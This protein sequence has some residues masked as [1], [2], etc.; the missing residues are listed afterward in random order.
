MKN[1]LLVL[2]LLSSCLYSTA[3]VGKTF[4]FAAPEVTISHATGQLSSNIR[5]S[6]FDSA[7]TVRI[8]QPAN[9]GTGIDFTI[10]VPANSSS[11]VDIT[12]DS[13]VV[14]SKPFDQVLQTGIK[15][16]SDVDVTVYYEVATQN[17]PDIFALK[18]DNGLGTEFYL[19]LLDVYPNH[20]FGGAGQTRAFSQFNIVAA[21]NNTTV[22]I[23]PSKD[24]FNHAGNV[25]YMI[26]LNEGETYSGR[27]LTEAG[28]SKPVGTIISSDKPIAVTYADDSVQPTSCFDLLGDQLV[29][30]N[31]IGEEYI[32]NSNAGNLNAGVA[33]HVVIVATENF[34]SIER[35][36]LPDTVLFAGQHYSDTITSTTYYRA[37]KPIYVIQITGF[38]CELGSAILPPLN[39]A[40]SDQ[41]S[42]GR[43]G[44]TGLSFFLSLLV[45]TGAEG[46]FTLNGDA[47]LIQASDFAVV[48][49]TGG[50]WMAMFKQFN[51]T[52]IPPGQAQLVQNTT[53][54]FSL[55]I[56][57][58]NTNGGTRYGYFSLFQSE[59]I[60]DANVDQFVCSGNQVNLNGSVRGGAVTGVWS[61]T[62][63]NGTFDDDTDL[64]TT[65]NPTPTDYATGNLTFV[66]E[67]TGQCFAEY[68][69]MVVNFTP[70]PTVDAGA[71][72]TICEN[73]PDLTLDATYNAIVT[74]GVQWSTKPNA[75][76]YSPGNTSDPTV[77]TPTAGQLSGGSFYVYAES[78][79]VGSCQPVTDS[80]LVTVLASPIV[81]AGPAQSLCE[82]NAD[83]TLAGSVTTYVGPNQGGVWS[84]GGN[85]VTPSNNALGGT[86]T[87]T[88]TEIANGTVTLTLS[89]LADPFCA[90]ETDN[91]TLTITSAPTV[92]A[93]TDQILCANNAAVPLAG[94][95]TAPATQATWIGGAGGFSSGRNNVNSIYTPTTGEI[96]AGTVTLTL[97][98]SAGNGTCIPVSDDVVLTYTAAPTMEAG[99]DASVCAN[100]AGTNV[101][102]VFT[103][104][105][106]VIWTNEAGTFTSTTDPL[107]YNPT[108]AE[109]T[110]GSVKLF[111]T[112]D[113]VGNC[114]D[115]IDSLTV[116]I[117]AAPI[118]EAG[119]ALTSCENNPTDTLQGSVTTFLGAGQGTWSG[120]AGSVSPSSAALQGIY[121]PSPAEI[122]NGTVLLTLTSTN[123]GICSAESDNVTLTILPAPTVSAGGDQTVCSNNADVTLNGSFT[124][125][126]GAVWVGGLGTFN[127][128]RN[129][130]NAVYT[131]DPTEVSAGTVS[132]TLQTVGNGLCLPESS[133]MTITFSASPTVDAGLGT[134]VC[135]NNSDASLS[136][137][138][139]IAT[140]VSW[141][142]GAG[143]YLPNAFS[144]NI[145]YQPT[146]TEISNGTVKLFATTTGIGNC[147]AV[148]DSVEITIME[149]PVVD[150][151][152]TLLAC[153]NNPTVQLDGSVIKFGGG[154]LGEGIWS[155]STGIINPTNDALKGTFTPTP[156]EI[157]NGTVLLTLTSI[158]NGVCNAESDTVS[159]NI[160]PSPT[161]NAG[162]DQFICK[163]NALTTLAGTSANAS[164]TTWIGGSG[165]FSPNRNIKTATYDPTQA[166]KDNGFVNL[167]L[168]TNPTGNCA[169][170]TDQM[171]INFTSEPT[172]DAGS[173]TTVC[174]NNEDVALTGSVSGATGGQW[175]NFGGSFV[176]GDQ[177]TLSSTYRPSA[178]EITA[179]QVV[180]FLST[181]GNGT[182]SSESDSIIV[183]I[184]PAPIVDAGAPFT[185]C[186]NN[187]TATLDG[188]FSG[189]GGVQWSNG[190]GSFIP[191]NQVRN[192]Q[193]IPS[194]AEITAGFVNLILTTTSN[195]LCNAVSDN[196]LINIR[197]K[198]VVSAG[199]DVTACEN[200]PGVTLTGSVSLAGGLVWSGG[201]GTF[202]PPSADQLTVQYNPTPTEINSG[203]VELYATS[204]SNALCNAVQDTVLVT[205]TSSPIVEAGDP[206]TVCGNNANTFLAGQVFGA[207]GGRWTNFNG[208]FNPDNTTL[209]ASYLPSAQ[210]ISNGSVVLYLESTGNGNCTAVQD[211]VEITI[212]PAPVASAGSPVTVCANNPD[213]SLAGTFSNAGGILWSGGA[214]SFVSSITDK[215]ATYTPTSGEI[216]A[217]SVTLTMTTTGNNTCF[218][219]S[220]NIVITI[221]GAP[222]ISAGSDITV[223]ANNS[224]VNLSGNHTI[225][226]GARWSGGLGTFAPND[227]VSNPVYTPTAAEVSSGSLTLT[228]ATTGNGICIPETDDVLITFTAAPSVEAGPIQTVC[229]N[230]SDVTLDGSF[231][232]ATGAAWSGF[233]GTF[234]PSSTD[235]KAIYT[236]SS[237]EVQAGSI[238]LTLSTTGNGT[239]SAVSDDLILNFSPEPFVDAGTDQFNCVDDMDT[240][241]NGIVAGGASTGRW[242]SSGT[243]LF[244]PADNVLNATY[245]MSAQDSLA[246][247]VTLTLTS[248]GNTNGSC[249][250]V[251]NDMSIFLTSPGIANAGTNKSV[252]ANNASV[253]L[254]GQVTGG[255]LGGTWTSSGSGQFLPDA[256]S[257]T[258]TYVPSAADT[259]NGNITITLTANS[260]DLNQDQMDLTITVGPTVDAGPNKTVCAA[261]GIIQLEGSVSGASTTGLWTP[262]SGG[263]ITP[264]LTSLTGQYQ[265]TAADE[266]NGSVRLLLLSTNVGT[267]TPVIDTVDFTI[268]QTGT[269]T[270]G[271]DFQVCS[272]NSDVQ[273]NGAFSGGATFARW[274]TSGT[275]SFTP[276]DTAMNALYVP[277]AADKTNGSVNLKYASNSC[278]NAADSLTITI[279]DGPVVDAGADVTVCE[280]N[281]QVVLSGSVNNAG[282]G[283]WTSTGSG[284]FSPTIF[285]LGATYTPAAS[286]V[287]VTVYLTSIG[288]GNCIEEKDSLTIT[289]TPKPV[290]DAGADQ[291]ICDG[292]SRVK[293][294]GTVSQGA[295]TGTWTSFGTGGFD[296]GAVLL[297]TDY[298]L[299]ASDSANRGVMLVLASTGNGLCNAES[300]TLM[301]SITDVGTSDAGADLQ[302]CA[303]DP[304]V[305][306]SGVIQGGAT[307][308]YWESNGTGVFALDSSQLTNTY[309]PSSQDSLNGT[310]TLSLVSNSCDGA[311]DD[312]IITITAAPFVNAGPDQIKCVNDLNIQLGGIVAGASTTGQWRSSGSGTFIPNAQTLN[313]TYQASS[314]DSIIGSVELI[315]E[316]T[317]IGNCLL[318]SDTMT[319]R[320]TTGGTASAGVDQFAC[321]NV[322]TFPLSGSFGGGASQGT[323]SSTGTGIFLPNAFD[324]NAEYSPSD[325]DKVNGL[326]TLTLS[327]N[328]CDMASDQ[329]D[330][331]IT[332]AP[333]VSAGNNL[334]LCENNTEASLLGSVAGA[335]GAV[336]SSTGSG[337][338]TP[339]NKSLSANYL[340]SVVDV[341]AGSVML[342]LTSVGN[343]NCTAERD[344]IIITF[345]GGPVPDAGINRSVCKNSPKTTLGGAVTGVTTTGQWSTL[346]GGFFLPNDTTLNAEYVFGPADTANGFVELILTST[347][348]V[349]CNSEDDT[350]T[351]TLGETTFAD[352]GND[353]FLCNENLLAQLNGI[354]GGDAQGG[355]W[356]SNGTGSFSPNAS[357]LNASYRF[358]VADSVNKQVQLVLTATAGNGCSSGT[359]TLDIFVTAEPSVNAGSNIVICPGRDTVTFAATGSGVISKQWIVGGSG[360]I[361][362]GADTSFKGQYL[363]STADKLNGG[364][365]LILTGTNAVGCQ[366]PADTL[367]ITIGNPLTMDYL[368]SNLCEGDETSFADSSK[369]TFGSITSWLWRFG[370]ASISDVQHPKHKYDNAGI[371]EISLTIT[372]DQ[373][374]VDSLK[375]TM[376][377]VVGPTADFQIDVPDVDAVF[378]GDSVTFIDQSINAAGW[379]WIVQNDTLFTKDA[380][381]TFNVEGTY[382]VELAVVS[383]VGCVDTISKELTVLSDAIL[384]PNVPNAFSPNE[385]GLNDVYIVRGGPFLTIDFKI[386]NEWGNVV[387]EST[388]PTLGWDGTRDGKDQPEGIYTYTLKATTLDGKDYVKSGDV[389]LIR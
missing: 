35:N 293:L 332:P 65:Y 297:E 330:L 86:Y 112:T 101:D 92:N 284:T 186:E 71:D 322:N 298:L 105:A 156:T 126:S 233:T 175:S 383:N 314:N 145:T 70:G 318:V 386:Y 313:A 261:S 242:T 357:T 207:T 312:K 372:T 32:V 354:I 282:G 150:A 33:E 84:N 124:V 94:S 160:I 266:A 345:T 25:P 199:T 253:L 59:I 215:N 260:C 111:A 283:I 231:S 295:S 80:L 252:C 34:T 99:L 381:A 131:P 193:Y 361:L 183:T 48:P 192:A 206:I 57:N 379:Q 167:T 90:V 348:N 103:G 263:S 218:A 179:G 202:T 209:N 235:P 10:N 239:C 9:L 189:A 340:P 46:D 258:T 370:D 373:G 82:N 303:N 96:S 83:F 143:N 147:S 39:C 335:G 15:I 63:G 310:V 327:T 256:T 165:V 307:Q 325:Q 280:N 240:D 244:L 50:Q 100:N 171:T 246:G 336:W 16:E 285:D 226:T 368:V 154:S 138:R 346:G 264:S 243:G 97:E 37:D 181:T 187:S 8:Y 343:G 11:F 76:S 389:T 26:T 292:I 77:F 64:G 69:T 21:E 24:I 122:S 173:N 213:V 162:T 3:Q 276:N 388:D 210:E 128:D 36:G 377:V 85:S 115:V 317:N 236:P 158:N 315:L 45:R 229:A 14:E 371:Y 117:N 338:F 237:T 1:F 241:L 62:N 98:S 93:G 168:Q 27:A 54:V 188:T 204:T 290:V 166:E 306:L 320:I 113:G 152:V 109:I 245:R 58:G 121:S 55:G 177:N 367:D 159:V 134:T 365:F 374:C 270:V 269:V 224:D 221:S 375:R 68:D 200:N 132:L 148:M 153:E 110:A 157:T 130:M 169:T 275:G 305:A 299:S 257:L 380:G 360:G 350:L 294:N 184:D 223:C 135:A 67:S 385:D 136:A 216:S 40:G 349:T 176:V 66:L 44:N 13:A 387:F 174:A 87:P 104:S 95:F 49:G 51:N 2:I 137:V 254:S 205:F 75:G 18:S 194:T 251:T 211:S 190:G 61:V 106:G 376:S 180:L 19:P 384:P 250:A 88:P 38:G 102:A 323:W 178:G 6:T 259:A 123:N 74:G 262:L 329:L 309:I 182:C 201:A 133:S 353:I 149:A 31:I 267:C 163:N 268:N 358:G 185:V 352:A 79:G 331:L 91:V 356:A 60:V 291:V 319:V 161:V 308:G 141:S 108:G 289:V 195:G 127:P 43:N 277:S 23:F 118:V 362:A 369:I 203:S 301:I 53:D 212:T 151:G 238:T 29:P 344:S 119:P 248:T 219:V 341:E 17:N 197:P 272:N 125:A 286:D 81:D 140:G 120:G 333:T 355:T 220:D 304:N 144:D 296:P 321:S 378:E 265:I 334:Q 326:I 351:I 364:T 363:L 342:F 30:R 12:N 300:D 196:V 191:S 22:W 271:Q 249:N 170:V 172:V 337:S 347:N 116:T 302:V 278:D 316:P 78:M 225:A 52:E 73:N 273:L 281:A 217:G 234:N 214:G 311:A 72:Q 56:V 230:N 279:I 198:P 208:S 20:V 41:V 7:A 47:S 89:S 359:D 339:S 324:M 155:G 382:S 228:Y 164:G 139:T 366:A 42:F 142:G 287:N 28:A 129:T 4:W 288:N 107:T 5:V 274:T 232:V 146:L 255:A 222:T 114:L 328:S 247:Q 227:S